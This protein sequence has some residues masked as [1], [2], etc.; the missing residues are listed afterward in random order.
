MKNLGKNLIETSIEEHEVK[1]E[2]Y[3]GLKLIEDGSH[4]GGTSIRYGM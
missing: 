4:M 2:G 3:K 1:S